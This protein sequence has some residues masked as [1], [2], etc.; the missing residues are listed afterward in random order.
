MKELFKEFEF[1]EKPNIMIEEFNGKQLPEDYINFMKSHN[2]GEGNIG[3]ASYGK[4]L[5]IEEL[6]EYYDDYDLSSVIPT[7]FVFGTDLGGN[8]WC[9]NFETKQYYAL[10]EID[11]YEDAYCFANSCQGC[12]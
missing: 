8:H 3:E 4:F 6:K 2:G 9:Y 7:S 12:F 10:D 11:N 1:N 5:Q